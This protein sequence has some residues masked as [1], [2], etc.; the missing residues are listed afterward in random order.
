MLL[1]P[2]IIIPWKHA[3][4]L[5]WFCPRNNIYGGCIM[6]APAHLE[7]LESQ[8]GWEQQRVSAVT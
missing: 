4:S 1:F 6:R 5:S 7:K 2:A 8:E 3:S